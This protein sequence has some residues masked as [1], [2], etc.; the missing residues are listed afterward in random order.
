MCQRK[1]PICSYDRVCG[2]GQ[3]GSYATGTLAIDVRG[4]VVG[5]EVPTV[6][7]WGLVVMTL[8]LLTAGTIVYTKRHPLAA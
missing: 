1:E 4:H 2:D 8:L 7:E 6:S 5:T 3:R